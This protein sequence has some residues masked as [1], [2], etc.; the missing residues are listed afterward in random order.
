MSPAD[1]TQAIAR[2]YMAH[3]RSVLE[4]VPLDAI[5]AVVDRLHIAYRERRKVLIIGNGGSAATASHMACDL[6]KNVL[7]DLSESVAGKG[8]FRVLALTD[9]AAMLTALANDTGYEAVFREQVRTLVEPGDVVIA[10]SGSGNSPNVV[11]AVK[12]AAALGADTIGLLGFSGG[13]LKRLVRTA[14]IVPGD[15]YG[16]I[17]DAHL[18]L[19]HIITNC[20]RARIE[21]AEQSSP[22]PR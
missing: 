9:N 8:R 5:A 12:L 21:A 22:H 15:E 7:R 3:L 14:V 19:N 1:D 6:A 17:E 18:V 13:A 4:R 20:L 16:P 10:I 2:S 11:E